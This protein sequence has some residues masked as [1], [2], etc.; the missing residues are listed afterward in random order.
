[1]LPDTPSSV[2]SRKAPKLF[3]SLGAPSQD[4]DLKAIA[5]LVGALPPEL[6]ALY[7]RHDGQTAEHPQP[8]FFDSYFIPLRGVDGIERELEKHGRGWLPFGKDFGGSFHALVL[9]PKRG[10]VGSVIFYDEDEGSHTVAPS[11]NAFF[12]R[13]AKDVEG[14]ARTLDDRLEHTATATLDALGTLAMGEEVRHPALTQAA[15]RLTRV[16]PLVIG[17]GTSAQRA[18]AARR[19]ELEAPGTIAF[20]V[21]KA[22]EASIELRPL[23][24]P[25]LS[26]E[27]GSYHHRIPDGGQQAIHYVKGTDRIE[28]RLRWRE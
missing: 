12:E 22:E 23:A 6:V 16:E 28:L 7:A 10:A 18:P 3:R 4:S 2:V 21:E 17:G 27:S 19:P 15:I 25:G 5:T 24:R 9:D 8:L 20:A 26:T 1:M 14:G 11:L 13:L